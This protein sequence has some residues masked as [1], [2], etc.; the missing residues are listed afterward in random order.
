[1]GTAAIEAAPTVWRWA[2]G[3]ES[4]A[5]AEKPLRKAVKVAEASE[6]KNLET[7]LKALATDERGRKQW[8]PEK[9]A[10]VQHIQ[11]L[12]EEAAKKMTDCGPLKEVHLTCSGP[13]ARIEPTGYICDSNAEL[14]RLEKIERGDDGA[15]TYKVLD[16]EVW[17]W[18][19]PS[20][21][22]AR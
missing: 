15:I 22:N 7:A 4:G 9:H 10:A 19:D 8:T 18:S 20:A 17:S 13:A 11:D 14:G 6:M 12:N 3:G 2:E 5:D 21:K 16:T 1:M